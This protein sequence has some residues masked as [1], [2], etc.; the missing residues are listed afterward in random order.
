MDA[1]TIVPLLKFVRIYSTK[2]I[3]DVYKKDEIYLNL[4]F[5]ICKNCIKMK[6]RNEYSFE[7]GV[8]KRY[9]AKVSFCYFL[10]NVYS[11]GVV[12]VFFLKNLLKWLT[13]K[14]PDRIPASLTEYNPEDSNSFAL[15][16]F[17]S[18]MYL[19]GEQP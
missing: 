5:F 17:K 4:V 16:S 1:L 3:S 15:D 12:P 7:K 2:I 14:K 11:T 10:A 19:I 6:K 9:D 18:W 13:S 8:R